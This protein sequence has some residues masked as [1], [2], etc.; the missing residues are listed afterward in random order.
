MFL[1]ISVERLPSVRKGQLQSLKAVEATDKW[2][3]E[4]RWSGLHCLVR[5]HKNM[6]LH[7][8]DW[9]W[10]YVSK[11]TGRKP[12][13]V[14]MP[15]SSKQWMF[16]P[17]CKPKIL[18]NLWS[19]SYKNWIFKVL[20]KSVLVFT[21]RF[22]R[23][24]NEDWRKDQPGPGDKAGK[25]WKASKRERPLLISIEDRMLSWMCLWSGSAWS[26][27]INLGS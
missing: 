18:K 15:A 7:L 5:E 1:N 10:S 16:W 24:S 2:G 12:K 23:A 3:A 8:G 19:Y 13:I 27:L 20:L 25:G 6:I 26:F 17:H 4:V 14:Y 9:L 22:R 11:S 21:S